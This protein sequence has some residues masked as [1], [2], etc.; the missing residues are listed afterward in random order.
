MLSTF[1]AQYTGFRNLKRNLRLKC[2][3]INQTDIAGSSFLHDNR[4][5]HRLCAAFNFFVYLALVASL[6]LV[7]SGAATEG[8]TPIFSL[9]IDELFSPH[10]CQFV[11]SQ[12]HPYL[13]SPEN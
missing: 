3:V 4:V 9:K 11:S 7:S 5:L 10:V 8:V 2:R 13:F 1:S 6:W 12:C